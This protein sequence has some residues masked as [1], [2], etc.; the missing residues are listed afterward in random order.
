MT[1]SLNEINK[2]LKESGHLVKIV[3]N[4]YGMK[5]LKFKKDC[6]DGVIFTNGYFLIFD[7]DNLIWSFG[8]SHISEDG[9]G[10]KNT[11]GRIFYENFENQAQ[12]S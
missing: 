2:L 4:G 3:E 5:G 8:Q 6:I 11:Y 10:A 12:L 9:H 7:Q 1:R